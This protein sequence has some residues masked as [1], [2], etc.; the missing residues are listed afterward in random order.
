MGTGFYPRDH[1]SGNVRK[2]GWPRGRGQPRSRGSSSIPGGA[3]CNAFTALLAYI[4][5]VR[6]PWLLLRHQPRSHQTQ[7]WRAGLSERRATRVPSR[8]PQSSS[9]SFPRAPTS[10]P[11]LAPPLA[12]P[13]PDKD[14]GMS[15]TCCHPATHPPRIIQFITQRCNCTNHSHPCAPSQP[16]YTAFRAVGGSQLAGSGPLAARWGHLVL[17]RGGGGRS[18]WPGRC[19]PAATHGARQMPGGAAPGPAIVCWPGTARHGRARLL[20][21][22]AG[23]QGQRWGFSLPAAGG[24]GR[25]GRLPE[26]VKDREVRVRL[27]NEEIRVTPPAG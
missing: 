5:R 25:E 18:G 2:N 7:C 6:E 3:D 10:Q 26:L 17:R 27:R 20:F 4:N 23:S 19:P 1:T 24:W 22:A 9:N 15:P 14:A 13:L 8:C 21:F 12:E 11:H 16:L